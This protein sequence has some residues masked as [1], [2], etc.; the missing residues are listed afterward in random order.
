M[1]HKT[2]KKFPFP[3]RI[4]PLPFTKNPLPLTQKNSPRVNNLSDFL[5]I[6]RLFYSAENKPKDNQSLKRNT[7]HKQNP[8]P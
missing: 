1:M 4:S 3:S 5:S 6:K 7:N 2:F 8:R